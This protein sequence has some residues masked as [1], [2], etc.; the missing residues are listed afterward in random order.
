[1]LAVKKI[2]FISDR[3]SCT[4]LRGRWFDI[5]VL[6]SDAPKQDK[7]YEMKDSFYDELKCVFD[8]FPKNH[9]N[10]LLHFNAKVGREESK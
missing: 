5:I 9:T 6:N 1:M 2:E 4:L 3:T 7:I 8:K 10:I